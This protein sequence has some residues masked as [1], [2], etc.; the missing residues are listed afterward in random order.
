M[1]NLLRADPLRTAPAVVVLAADSQLEGRALSGA[2][3]ERLLRAYELLR[4]GCAPLMVLTRLAPH[5]AAYRLQVEAQ[6]ASLGFEFD[7]AE[8]GP[9]RNTRD[10]AVVVAALA[11]E[12]GWKEVILVTHPWHMR[13]A[14]AAFEQEGLPVICTPCADGE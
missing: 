12:R 8:V 11:R 2:S 9:V 7:V 10:E 13:R 3:Q 14:A 5:S 4:H 6:L 1:R